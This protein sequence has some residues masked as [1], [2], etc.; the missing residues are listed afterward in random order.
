[1]MKTKK[2]MTQSE[3]LKTSIKKNCEWDALTG[4]IKSERHNEALEKS[5]PQ[6]DCIDTNTDK[7]DF[8]NWDGLLG[9]ISMSV[10]VKN[11]DKR[12]EQCHNWDGGWC[13]T[14]GA[15]RKEGDSCIEE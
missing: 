6:L 2:T 15:Y 8:S 4:H 13:W 10:N 14:V 5:T 12:C 7:T 11:S 3:D 1:M 9:Y